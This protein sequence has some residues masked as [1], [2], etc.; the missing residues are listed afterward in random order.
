ELS[1]R[2]PRAS[3]QNQRARIPGQTRG[4][5]HADRR[6][7]IEGR[8]RVRDLRRMGENDRERARGYPKHPLRSVARE[9]RREG[10]GEKKRRRGA[11]EILHCTSPLTG[12]SE[13]RQALPAASR[14]GIA[15]IG[16]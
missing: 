16:L 4:G 13:I 5:G 1:G 15:E 3:R 9:L 14:S 12:G 6:D 10:A 2:Q 8:G 7:S 11:A